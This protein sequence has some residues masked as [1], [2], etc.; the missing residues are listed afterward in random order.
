MMARARLVEVRVW[1]GMGILSR[2]WLG[3]ERGHALD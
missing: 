2:S 1:L 3:S